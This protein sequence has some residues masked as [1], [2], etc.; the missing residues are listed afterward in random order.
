MSKYPLG[1]VP[2][3]DCVAIRIATIIGGYSGINVFLGDRI[4]FRGD[5]PGCGVIDRHTRSMTSAEGS[6]TERSMTPL[7]G[8]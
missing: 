3:A 7:W 2:A 5:W 8:Y 4:A 1:F 6:S